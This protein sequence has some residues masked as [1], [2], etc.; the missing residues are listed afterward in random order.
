[1]P[2]VELVGCCSVRIVLLQQ[3]ARA[4]YCEEVDTSAS[5]SAWVDGRKR[6]LLFAKSVSYHLYFSPLARRVAFLLTSP[7]DNALDTA[8]Q[9]FA[10]AADLL[11][12][13]PF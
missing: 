9:I 13:Q 8:Q 10:G 12:R 7:G 11:C 2:F 5:C 6:M 3:K 4:R 1:M